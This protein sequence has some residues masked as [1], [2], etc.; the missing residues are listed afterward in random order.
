MILKKFE[1]KK[2]E[3]LNKIKIIAKISRFYNLRVLYLPLYSSY[4]IKKMFQKIVKWKRKIREIKRNGKWDG[5][6]K[7]WIGN[8]L[9]NKMEIFGWKNDEMTRKIEE[10]RWKNGEMRWKFAKL[11]G[12]LRKWDG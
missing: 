2:K 4:F 1:C 11:N 12:K 5:K 8:I 6:L 10:T 9:E 3:I 7:K